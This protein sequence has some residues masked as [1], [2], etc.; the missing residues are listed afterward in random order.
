YWPLFTGISI[1]I[2]FSGL[3]V[4]DKTLLVTAV[5]LVLVFICIVNWGLEPF[6][7]H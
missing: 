1:A 4:V 7:Q 5:G 3:L 2:A 6:E